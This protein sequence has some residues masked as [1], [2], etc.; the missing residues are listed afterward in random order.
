MPKPIHSGPQDD[1]P[2]SR[3]RRLMN[4]KEYATMNETTNSPSN[5][6]SARRRLIRGVFA[7]P[8]ALTLYSGSAFAQAST[9]LRVLERQ[10][11]DPQFPV[12]P[13]DTWVRV[14]VYMS[15]GVKVVW[16]ADVLESGYALTSFVASNASWATVADPSEPHTPSGTPTLSSPSEYAALRFNERGIIIGVVA[17][18][19]NT[20]TAVTQSALVSFSGA[21]GN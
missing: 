1:A 15:N 11:A 4:A 19:S 18:G 8:A 6:A 17:A 16:G 12:N 13:T 10:L 2:E 3:Q 14:P 21:I 5:R 7:A 9:S 20:G